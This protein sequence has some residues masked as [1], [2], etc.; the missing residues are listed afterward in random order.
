MNITIYV[1]GVFETRSGDIA[2]ITMELID[3]VFAGCVVFQSKKKKICSWNE[4]GTF[5][6]RN[7]K[8]HEFDIVKTISVF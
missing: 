2:F 4:D 8:P 3:H 5:T 6:D 7:G 1:T